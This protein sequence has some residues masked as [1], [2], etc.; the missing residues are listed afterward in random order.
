MG[1]TVAL[2]KCGTEYATFHLSRIVNRQSVGAHYARIASGPSSAPKLARSDLIQRARN[3]PGYAA[4]FRAARGRRDRSM[5][6]ID[7]CRPRGLRFSR[8]AYDFLLEAMH[9]GAFR[10]GMRQQ[11]ELRR[12][13]SPFCSVAGSSSTAWPSRKK[14]TMA[15]LQIGRTWQYRLR[16]PQ[17]VFWLMEN[18]LWAKM[19][20]TRR[21]RFDG[22]AAVGPK[23]AGWI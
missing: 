6:G 14:A 23:G 13:T 7:H 2:R 10:K 11:S 22:P 21:L 20:T 12:H 8:E 5:P 17:R 3:F 16:Y 4:G 18:H 9:G 15:G 19:P 1:R